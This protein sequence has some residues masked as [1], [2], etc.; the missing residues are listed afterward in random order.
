M[1]I[2]ILKTCSGERFTYYEGEVVEAKQEIAKELI[3]A[4]YAKPLTKAELADK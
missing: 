4:G 3:R 2:K 1:V